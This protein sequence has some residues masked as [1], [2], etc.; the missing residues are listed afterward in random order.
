MGS[1]PTLSVSSCQLVVVDLAPD[2]FGAMLLNESRVCPCLF[3]F[4]C[5]RIL[6]CF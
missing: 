4:G 1:N 3:D 6:L 2:P 5:G